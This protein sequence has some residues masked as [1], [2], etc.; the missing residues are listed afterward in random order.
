MSQWPGPPSS[1]NRPR[2]TAE[3]R[4]DS[5]TGAILMKTS[6]TRD[7]RVLCPNEPMER[8]EWRQRPHTILRPPGRFDLEQ[9]QF[10]DRVPACRV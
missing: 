9:G 6:E 1:V 4:T 8:D 3:A 5:L 10:G 2:Q 7:L